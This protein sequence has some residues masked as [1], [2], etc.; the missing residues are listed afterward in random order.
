VEGRRKGAT[1]IELDIGEALPDARGG[2]SYH[3]DALDFA[4]LLAEDPP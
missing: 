2:V 1:D 3:A 4:G